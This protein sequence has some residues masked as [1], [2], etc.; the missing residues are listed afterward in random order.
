MMNEAAPEETEP[1]ILIAVGDV[2]GRADLLDALID[3][4]ERKAKGRR[5]RFVLL[6]DYVDRGPDSRGVL[7]RLLALRARRPDTILLKG[8][9]EQG[10]LDFL[11]EPDQ[12]DAWLS[13]GGRE[14]LRSYGV[15]VGEQDEPRALRDRFAEAL[16]D[17]HF[18]LLMSLPLTYEV[19]GYLFVH[20]GLHPDRPIEAQRERDLL[21]VRRAWLE[22]G[23]D[24]F[25]P[26]V[27]HG[28]TPV[29]RPENLSWRVNVDTGAVW[30]SRLSALWLERG[31]RR[32]L[33]T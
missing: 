18:A 26:V 9:H 24:R 31:R 25:E 29:D 33:N 32:F 30:S 11:A 2:H 20:A 5:C 16:P 3:K 12:V 23:K 7:D 21:W 4:A 15:A 19:P 13:W 22:G 8:N 1:P 27:V 17:E 10:L 6:G 14:T 28:H